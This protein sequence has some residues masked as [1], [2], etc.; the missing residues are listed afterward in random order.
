MGFADFL[1]S[2]RN[3]VGSG[4]AAGSL[5]GFAIAGLAW[6]VG[7][8]AAAAAYGIGVALTPKGGR[9]LE[10][11]SSLQEALGLAGELKGL[12][13]KMS[14]KSAHLP[15]DVN[16]A[17]DRV[18]ELLK[19]ILT[20]P[21]QLASSAHQLFTVSRSIR[22]YVPS[23]IDAF[24]ALPADYRARRVRSGRTAEEELLFQMTLLGD[25]LTRVREA[26]YAGDA[27]ALADH[28][29]FLEDK[30]TASALDPPDLNLG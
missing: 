30:F 20:R 8:L 1:T 17:W 23:S 29:R 7:P 22:D 28:G 26:V 4:L 12:S 6:P 11:P 18:R 2:R 10:G 25:E 13:D 16:V 27:K 14:Y 5:A 24:L 19:A 3:L 15:R 21:E 9:G